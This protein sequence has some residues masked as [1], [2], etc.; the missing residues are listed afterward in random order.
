MD[1][2]KA[3][4]PKCGN[5]VGFVRMGSVKRCP[6]CGFQYTVAPPKLPGVEEDRGDSIGFLGLF[7]RLILIMAIIAVVSVGVLFVGCSYAFRNW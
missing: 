7:L 4:C 5:E 3:I 2:T 1:A 6:V